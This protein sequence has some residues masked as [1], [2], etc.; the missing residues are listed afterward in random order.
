MKKNRII[1]CLLCIVFTAT[2][3]FNSIAFAST[4]TTWSVTQYSGSCGKNNTSKAT[5]KMMKATNAELVN[6]IHDNER[7]VISGSD[8]MEDYL[9]YTNG[10]TNSPWYDIIWDSNSIVVEEGITRIGDNAFIG[11]TS[12]CYISLPESLQSIGHYAF[13]S[14]LKYVKKV[15]IPENVTYIGQYAFCSNEFTEVEILGNVEVLQESVFS[16][17]QSLKT[18]TIPKSVTEIQDYAFDYCTSLT[19]VYYD[20]TRSEWEEIN[21]GS[22][23]TYLLNATVHFPIVNVERVTLDRASKTMFVGSTFTLTPSISPENADNKTISWKSSNSSVATVN[24]GVVTAVSPGTATITVTTAD[25]NKTATCTVSVQASTVSVSGIEL[26]KSEIELEIGYTETLVATISPTNATNKSVTWTTSNE[27]VVSVQ[28]GTLT[29]KETGDAI[30]TVTTTDGGYSDTCY[31]NVIEPIVNVTGI[32]L[33][34]TSEELPVGA[35]IPIEAIITP[36]NATNREVIWT[37]SDENV[38]V[39]DR[40]GE[41][42]N[43]HAV[44]VGTATITATTVDGSKSSECIIVVK[45]RKPSSGGSTSP[46]D[47]DEPS[48]ELTLTRGSMCAKIVEAFEFELTEQVEESPFSDIDETD[49]YYEE[50]L[51]CNQLEIVSGY[52]DG[53]FKPNG[54]ITNAEVAKLIYSTL[55]YIGW[56]VEIPED[57]DYDKTMWYGQ[58]AWLVEDLGIMID[59]DN[60]FDVATEES[61]TS[62]LGSIGYVYQNHI[63]E[64]SNVSQYMLEVGNNV[65]LKDNEEIECN[66]APILNEGTIFA[67]IRTF[68]NILN[69]AVEY[70]GETREVTFVG[71]EK[72]LKYTVGDENCI[73]SNGVTYVNAELI[74]TEIIGE[75]YDI[76]ADEE[77]LIATKKVEIEENT[78]INVGNATTRKGQEITIPISISNNTGLTGLQF[79]CNYDDVLTLTNVEVGTALNGLNF[80]TPGD[81]TANPVTLLWDGIEADKSNGEIL[82]LTFKVDDNVEIGDYDISMTVKSAIDQDLNDV[83]LKIK[84]GTISIVEYIPGDVDENGEVNS[85]DIVLTRRFVAGGY[86]ASILEVAADVDA[87]GDVNSRDIVL[88]RRYIAGGYGVVLK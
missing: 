66:Y 38:V 4:E 61:I 30:I 81:L 41:L 72:I 21:I 10:R 83:D 56:S 18:V 24:N 14:A 26:N 29:A 78:Y 46:D 69:V 42:T 31:V 57:A 2:M 52:E 60:W 7:L 62:M 35:S 76:T 68:A 48:G 71:W 43:A 37:S 3:A 47:E 73:V 40:S 8:E 19:D 6:N 87:N 15:T 88:M 55:S 1:S 63:S 33:S 5:W 51:I 17:C 27:N 22:G 9:Q 25:G 84:G 12:I 86:G 49:E 20:G 28:N 13:S 34:I 65:V 39:V 74:F 53:T 80:T 16:S 32:E 79:E 85:R 59:I 64:S 44:A 70:N 45:E 67:S 54:S 82:I 58:Y 11:A 50:I 77:K 36:E 75:N 23:N